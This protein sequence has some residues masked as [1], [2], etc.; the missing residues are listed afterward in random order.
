MIYAVVLTHFK[1]FQ[2]K[3][4]HAWKNTRSSSYVYDAPKSSLVLGEGMHIAV[5][6]V[7]YKTLKGECRGYA[8]GFEGKP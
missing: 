5:Q 1:D 2:A 7:A 4:N 3:E 6:C 8:R